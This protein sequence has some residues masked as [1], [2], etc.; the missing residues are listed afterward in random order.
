MKSAELCYM[1]KFEQSFFHFPLE[2][3]KHT[4]FQF[5]EIHEMQTNPKLKE[6]TGLPFKLVYDTDTDWKIFTMITKVHTVWQVVYTYL[7]NYQQIG[8]N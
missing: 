1:D 2:L 5:A 7:I 4:H 6:W 3:G 8:W